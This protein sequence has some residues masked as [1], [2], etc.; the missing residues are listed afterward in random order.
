MET[1]IC[2]IAGEDHTLTVFVVLQVEF[3]RVPSD[4]GLSPSMNA[5]VHDLEFNRLVTSTEKYSVSPDDWLHGQAVAT[6]LSSER[7]TSAMWDMACLLPGPHLPD[8]KTFR[9]LQRT[10]LTIDTR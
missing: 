8:S 4:S 6:G 2:D 10:L 9:W 3:E 5:A 7:A 1:F